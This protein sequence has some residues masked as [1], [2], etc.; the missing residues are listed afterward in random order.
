MTDDTA[1]ENVLV[2]VV[3]A[4][5]VDRVGCYAGGDLTPTMDA[6]AERGEVFEQCYACAN[7]TSPSM[8]T[9]H[10]GLYP[11]RHGVRNHSPNVTDG[12]RRQVAATTN[13][14][15]FLA[16]S[17]VSIACD[18]LT[19][20]PQRRGYASYY[21]DGYDPNEDRFQTVGRG[22]V[23]TDEFQA[24]LDAVAT[25]QSWFGLVH[26]WDTHFPYNAPE[27]HREAVA[28]RA[29]PDDEYPLA[30]LAAEYPEGSF[31]R[32]RLADVPVETVADYKRRYD[33]S[34]KF[35][36]EQLR[37]LRETLRSRGELDDTAVV[38]TADHGESL[39]EHGISFDHHGL[40]DPSV[41][42]PLIVDAPGF[43]GR[44]SGFVQHFD[45]APTVLDLVGASG[46]DTRFDGRSLAPR[47]GGERRLDRDIVVFEEAHTA[48]KRAVRTRNYKYIT[49]LESDDGS[50]A[51]CDRPH[52][53]S[54][55][56][57]DLAADPEETRNVASER[58][59]VVD[60]LRDRLRDWL[61]ARPDAEQDA[62][63][64][65]ERDPAVRER[66]ESLGYRF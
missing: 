42:V 51:W 7:L 15:E 9:L 33:A 16:D 21:P 46:P 47:D 27:R 10:T 36:D 29:Y 49:R 40:Y 20:Q 35:V 43:D 57:Y 11:T 28:N 32:E 18:L 53:E 52:G 61:A 59:S 65:V 37:R 24:R 12:E 38:V 54:P 5:R 56:L 55:E 62:T 23:L 1:V 3:D 64:T 13:L 17:H 66:L 4:L 6:V 26:Y 58:P 8:T 19:W 41:H 48:R 2:V 50:C 25:D 22:D 34:V 14:P 30:D 63:H 60:A 45:V 39:V 31:S 44:E